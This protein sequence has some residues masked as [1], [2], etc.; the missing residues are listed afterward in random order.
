MDNFLSA[1][2]NLM[3]NYGRYSFLR[4]L[5]SSK[6]VIHGK[7]VRDSRWCIRYWPRFETCFILR[8]NP[9]HRMGTTILQ[10]G[11]ILTFYWTFEAVCPPPPPPLEFI[12][13]IYLKCHGTVKYMCV[14]CGSFTSLDFS[15]YGF[16]KIAKIQRMHKYTLSN[17]HTDTY[18]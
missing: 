11:K 5:C 10:I 14:W 8:T 15:I 9:M 4:I 6:C 7:Y 12:I 2:L 3:Q 13:R 18:H 16:P 17:Q 1:Y